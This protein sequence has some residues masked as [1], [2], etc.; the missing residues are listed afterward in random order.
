MARRFV[1][2]RCVVGHW[3]VS[4]CA[5]FCVPC[6]PAYA[7]LNLS[8]E[9]WTRLFGRT[10]MATFDTVIQRELESC[11]A[12]LKELQ[13]PCACNAYSDAT[14]V[15]NP[16]A[17]LT[18]DEWKSVQDTPNSTSSYSGTSALSSHAWAA[19]TILKAMPIDI[20]VLRW[21]NYQLRA[22]GYKPTRPDALVLNFGADLAN[23]KAFAELLHSMSQS[24]YAKATRGCTCGR[25]RVF[26]KFS[27]GLL[28]QD[29]AC[30]ASEVIE[31]LN[32][33]HTPVALT[34]PELMNSGATDSN[35]AV[36]AYLMCTYPSTIVERAASVQ[37][38]ID[39]LCTDGVTWRPGDEFNT[40]M[41]AAGVVKL[42][43][44]PTKH[45]SPL[46]M[47]LRSPM[48]Q[49]MVEKGELSAKGE[50]HLWAGLAL[51]TWACAF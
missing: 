47:A 22:H 39:K 27:P 9:N 36:A 32:R 4:R 20:L 17:L 15:V 25:C 37:A 51:L 46:K 8:T 12:D 7:L 42:A 48:R 24:D 23:G 26:P 18:S 50:W 13:L 30:A 28:N 14:P 29:P 31:R 16:W 49:R 10:W 38:V 45:V 6:T 11:A 40:K 35:I 44:S 3:R 21:F 41:H 5:V 2:L 19:L 33:I 1:L 43:L 34:S